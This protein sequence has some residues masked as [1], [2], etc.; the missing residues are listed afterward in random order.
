MKDMFW[1]CDIILYGSISILKKI[2]KMLPYDF[3]VGLQNIPYHIKV[4]FAIFS[5][6]EP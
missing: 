6:E 5:C 4:K 2:T 1:L 3:Y